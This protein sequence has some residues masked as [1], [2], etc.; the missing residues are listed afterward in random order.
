MISDKIIKLVHPYTT[1]I[2]SDKEAEDYN[3]NQCNNCP[4]HKESVECN[5]ETVS[6]C[7]K[8]KSSVTK[9]FFPD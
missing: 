4:R 7:I 6:E 2:A 3:L 8:V 1:T 9:F 5:T